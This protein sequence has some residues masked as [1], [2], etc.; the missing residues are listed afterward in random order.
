MTKPDPIIALVERY[1]AVCNAPGESSEALKESTLKI[2]RLIAAGEADL[3]EIEAQRKIALME[4]QVSELA[5][6]RAT[7]T[8]RESELKLVINSAAEMLAALELRLAEV[9]EVERMAAK[10]AK[11]AELVARRDADSAR[12]KD[13]LTRI[14][15]EGRE[16]V[17]E[18]LTL[19]EA[20]REFNQGLASGADK[21]ASIEVERR[22][23]IQPAKVVAE[24]RFVAF[25][26]GG[27]IEGEEGFVIA[28]GEADGTWRVDV[29][30]QCTAGHAEISGC[31]RVKYVERTT[32]EYPSPPPK[33][34]WV[35]DLRIPAFAGADP[36]WWDGGGDLSN[37]LRRLDEL[38]AP[39]PRRPRIRHV[40]VPDDGVAAAPA[41]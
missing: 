29:P 3:V 11:R 22:A 15:R 37:L 1:R 33:A 34:W 9:R 7:L 21:I 17:R 26:R 6:T 10:A 32:E 13:Y 16:V 5:K 24:R 30:S 39:P 41:E 2:Q 4:G 35:T 14:G 23:P 25:V 38:E 20:I 31:A 18:D 8:E 27:W 36:D 12:V 40:L 19:E 28:Y